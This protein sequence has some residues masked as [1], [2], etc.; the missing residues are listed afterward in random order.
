MKLKYLSDLALY[1]VEQPF[2]MFG[3][4]TPESPV[5]TNC[6]FSI[7]EDV[8]VTDVRNSSQDLGL[9]TSGFLFMKHASSFAI[10]LGLVNAAEI[11]PG[12]F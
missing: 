11:E 6:E 2:E 9:D 4:P 7:K 1:D 8:L 3:H 10:G 5:I 12:N